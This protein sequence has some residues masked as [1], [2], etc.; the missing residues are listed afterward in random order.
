MSKK[1]ESL[2]CKGVEQLCKL[3]CPTV[4]QKLCRY[5]REVG[6]LNGFFSF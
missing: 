2:W 1:V 5:L 3:K 4:G 6:T